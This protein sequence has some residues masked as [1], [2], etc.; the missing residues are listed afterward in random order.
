MRAEPHAVAR[1]GRRQPRGRVA[2]SDEAVVALRLGPRREGAL[3]QRLACLVQRRKRGGRPRRR[4]PGPRVVAVWVGHGRGA[5]GPA[6]GGSTPGTGWAAPGRG[7]T[8]AGASNRGGGG[9]GGSTPASV[10][11]RGTGISSPANTTTTSQN[12]QRRPRGS[13]RASTGG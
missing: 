12:S 6:A 2:V 3:P 13:G 11:R 5:S 1:G 4:G 7:W 8:G 10:C 9:G